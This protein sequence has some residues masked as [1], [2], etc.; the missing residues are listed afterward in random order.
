MF[1]SHF[2]III[3]CQFGIRGRRYILGG[4]MKKD[5]SPHSINRV[6]SGGVRFEIVNKGLLK[7]NEV[8]M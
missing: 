6:L 4:I 7:Y 8:N 1:E 2:L 5:Y 3:R